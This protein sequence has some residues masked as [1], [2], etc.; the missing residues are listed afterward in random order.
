MRKEAEKL[1]ALT[2]VLEDCRKKGITVEDLI[3]AVVALIGN[4]PEVQPEENI[5]VKISNL[6]KEIGVPAHIK[7]YK[8]LKY[9]II[10]VMEDGSLMEHVT[11]A[12]YPSVAKHF[13]TTALRVER[14]IRHAIE[15]AWDRGNVVVLEKYF[16]YTILPS[17]G[18]PTNS[19][20]IAM[21]VDYLKIN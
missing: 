13:D 5:E 18:K 6:L 16:G 4:K 11:K 7:G 17:R 20:F 19:E 1:N 15:V 8:Y 9:S 14:A 10:C 3:E 21:M 12:L 2:E